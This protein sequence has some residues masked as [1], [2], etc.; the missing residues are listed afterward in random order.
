MVQSSGTAVLYRSQTATHYERL[1][2]V[3]RQHYRG[4]STARGEQ[5]REPGAAERISFL[6]TRIPST[7]P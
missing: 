7:Q 6:Y 2:T 3:Q 4:A 5:A 1:Y